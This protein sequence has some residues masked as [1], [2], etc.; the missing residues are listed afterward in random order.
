MKLRAAGGRPY[1]TVA[2]KELKGCPVLA[3][4]DIRKIFSSGETVG[5][6]KRCRVIFIIDKKKKQ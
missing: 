3:D 6:L 5:Q 2:V 1:Y 4:R